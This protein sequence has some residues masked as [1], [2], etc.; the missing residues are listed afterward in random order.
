[1][2]R[3]TKYTHIFL[4]SLLHAPDSLMDHNFRLA[5]SVSLSWAYGLDI[6]PGD[7]KYVTLAQKA[8]EG[9]KLA[10]IPGRFL[11]D[12]FPILR[13]APDWVAF[14]RRA[15]VWKDDTEV[16]LQVP[17][18][19]AKLNLSAQSNRVS[20]TSVISSLIYLSD[21]AI[22]ATNERILKGASATVYMG[23]RS[24][25]AASV[26][27]FF[28]AMACHPAIQKRAQEETDLLLM[29]YEQRLP[30]HDDSLHLPYCMAVVFEVLGWE[31]AGPISIPHINIEGD[32][33]EGY[34]IPKSSIVIPNVW[35]RSENFPKPS[36]FR[37]ERF[38]RADGTLNGAMVK[39]AE[40]IFG[41]ERRFVP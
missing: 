8:L 17:F 26:D 32:V 25:T 1:R 22:E 19:D 24:T 14:K 33:Y 21:K 13:F 40:I 29:R 6:T 11:V 16:F 10:L 5:G 3:V 31:T 37:P 35:C 34:R 7:N 12:M 38:L 4:R 30:T 41:F 27:V 15:K 9:L 18:H 39:E 23:L 20:T 36:E 2:P 28:L